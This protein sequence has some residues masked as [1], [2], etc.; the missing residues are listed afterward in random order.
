MEV[1]D[2]DEGEDEEAGMAVPST[3]ADVFRVGSKG[4]SEFRVALVST[5]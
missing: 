1:K 2:E 5:K 3:A 4:L